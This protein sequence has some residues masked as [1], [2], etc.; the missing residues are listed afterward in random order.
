[1]RVTVLEQICRALRGERQDLRTMFA[2]KHQRNILHFCQPV[3][4][5]IIE[6]AVFAGKLD[7]PGYWKNPRTYQRCVFIPPGQEPIDPLRESKANRD[8]IEGRL[9]SPQEIVAKRGRDIEEV[10]DE[11]QE[12]EEMLAERGLLADAGDV[13]LASAPSALGA[14]SNKDIAD[15]V[16]RSVEDALDRRE[17]LK[18]TEE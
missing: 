17:L 1:M 3:T 15:I 7:L 12:Y 5:D 6:Q 9:R 8:D 13:S 4:R 11:C 14:K 18:E 2:P 16:S 10:L